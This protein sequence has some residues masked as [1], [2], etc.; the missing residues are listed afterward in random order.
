MSHEHRLQECQEKFEMV[1]KDIG[2][3]W[4]K[5]SNKVNGWGLLPQIGVSLLLGLILFVMG[6]IFWGRLCTV[7]AEAKEEDRAI[8]TERDTFR[9]NYW[10]TNQDILLVLQDLKKDMG[11]IKQNMERNIK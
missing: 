1:E 7:E 5:K 9:A 8:K 11:Y 4:E 3:L 2:T 10:K 6:T